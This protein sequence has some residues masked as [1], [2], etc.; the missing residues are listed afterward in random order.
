MKNTPQN[1]SLICKPTRRS[2]TPSGALQLARSAAGGGCSA[3]AALSPAALLLHAAPGACGAL[4]HTSRRQPPVQLSGA[5]ALVSSCCTPALHTPALHTSLTP[6]PNRTAA[7]CQ[8][9]RPPA[10][11]THFPQLPSR[12]RHLP[13]QQAR[14]ARCA[15][16]A[17]CAAVPAPAHMPPGPAG[18]SPSRR[19]CRCCMT[20]PYPLHP[21]PAP[22]SQ[23]M[24]GDALLVAPVL[25][26]GATAVDTYFPQVCCGVLRCAARCAACCAGL[27]PHPHSPSPTVHPRIVFPL[28]SPP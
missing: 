14:R 23:F 28:C 4:K 13:A 20:P 5:H 16:C 7:E 12:S 22:R 6:R 19:R 17:F 18:G 26:A 25:A 3:G 1:P 21:N 2:A 11:P 15:R 9:D 27:R 10:V 24:L 8:R